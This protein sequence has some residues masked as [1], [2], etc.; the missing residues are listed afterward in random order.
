MKKYFEILTR[1]PLFS[2]IEP[3]NLETVIDCLNGKT[4]KVN[5]GDPVFMAGD[6]V[7]YIGVV[8]AGAVQVVR[9]DYYGN[10][11]VMAIMEAG[12]MFAEAFV[13][14]ELAIMPV[15]VIAI[16]P[17]II[18]LLDCK[19]VIEADEYDCRFTRQVRRNLLR[20]TAQK[21]LMLTQKIRYMSQKTTKDKVMAFLMDQAK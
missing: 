13:C 3:E 9:D 15:S 1:C 14:S 21:N 10:R 17:S 7:Q 16:Q 20:S 5:K 2:G 8:L 12:G 11:S 4:I 19:S 18:L 6:A